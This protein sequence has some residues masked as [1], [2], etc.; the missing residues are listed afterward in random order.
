VITQHLG[1]F[2]TPQCRALLRNSVLRLLFHTSHSELAELADTLGL[3]PEDLEAIA[4]LET[5]K[6]EY[7]SCF[8]DSEAHGRTT[9][10]IYLSDIE[11]WACSADPDRDQPIRALALNEAGGDAWQ[12]M[13]RLVDPDWHHRHAD[14][15]LAATSEVD[16]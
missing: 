2:D 12:A 7:A 16:A 15:R 5:R 4:A 6:G 9:V 3:H 13:R 1:D 10:R 11:Y 14:Q 8:L